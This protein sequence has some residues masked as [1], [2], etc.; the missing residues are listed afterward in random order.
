M[1]EKDLIYKDKDYEIYKK[2]AGDLGTMLEQIDIAEIGIDGLGNIK[3]HFKFE[4]DYYGIIDKLI[5]KLELLKN[6]E[7]V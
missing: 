2:Y 1:K 7:E 4:E 5:A 3:H 6:K